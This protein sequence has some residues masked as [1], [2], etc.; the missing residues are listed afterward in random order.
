MIIEKFTEWLRNVRGYSD[1][2][3]K[4][5]NRTMLK[6]KQYLTATKRS[7]EKTDKINI[8]VI[9]KFISVQRENLDVKT[10]NNYL[11]CIKL[12]LKYCRVKGLKC[13]DYTRILFAREP[14][15]KIEALSKDDTNKMFKYLKD[16]EPETKHGELIRLRNLVMLH[17]LVYTGLRVSELANLKVKDI[18]EE[19]VING[20]W[21]KVRVVNLY[22]DDLRLINVYL[23]NR[24]KRETEYLFFSVSGRTK[25][26]KL[27]T[28]SIEKTIRDLGEAAGVKTKVFPHKLRHTFATNLLRANANIVHIQKLMGHSSI[29]TT[30][31]Y[32]TVLNSELRDTQKLL[33]Q[34]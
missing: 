9:E 10:C 7:I 3:V 34:C 21:N 30:Q 15:R 27:S 28:V 1:N 24:R 5:Y 26:Q 25:G 2:T 12:F 11:S 4:N 29:L 8:N 33:H 17:L 18:A 19:V 16:L 6:F 22:E 31:T 32:L 14:K 23:F 13:E 20:K